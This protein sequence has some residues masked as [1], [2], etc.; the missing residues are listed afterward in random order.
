MTPKKGLK[1]P[2]RREERPFGRNIKTREYCNIISLTGLVEPN[3]RKT[4]DEEFLKF[5]N[6]C[7][8]RVRNFKSFPKET[9]QAI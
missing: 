8:K 6:E 7:H 4:G 2:F 9:R 5:I 1:I 3:N